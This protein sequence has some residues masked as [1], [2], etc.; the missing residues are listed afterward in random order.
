V[1]GGE[2]DVSSVLRAESIHGCRSSFFADTRR[3]GSFWKQ[4]YRK[5]LT[6]CA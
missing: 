4:W 5:S 1:V 3:L 2:V 6:T